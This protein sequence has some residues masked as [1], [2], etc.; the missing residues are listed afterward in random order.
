MV[1]TPPPAVA[2]SVVVPPLQAI[3]PADALAVIAVGCVMVTGTVIVQLFASFTV[4]V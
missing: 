2:V 4:N 1:S 3:V